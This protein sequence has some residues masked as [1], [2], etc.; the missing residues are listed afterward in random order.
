MDNIGLVFKN[1]TARKG[2]YLWMGIKMIR[3]FKSYV[4]IFEKTLR[5]FFLR[6]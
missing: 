2:K 6:V 1:E 5:N 3:F 4:S